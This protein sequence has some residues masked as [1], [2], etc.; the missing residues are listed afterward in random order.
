MKDSRKLGET[1][2][3][4]TQTKTELSSREAGIE[5]IKSIDISASNDSPGTREEYERDSH[6]LV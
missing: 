3:E 2:D 1:M 6:E 4:R 5:E